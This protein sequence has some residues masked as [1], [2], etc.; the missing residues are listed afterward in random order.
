MRKEREG[1][2]GR[3]EKVWGKEDGWKTM[4]RERGREA[5]GEKERMYL[6]L[7]IVVENRI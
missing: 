3:R 1:K 7:R 2:K 4:V 6:M 5:K